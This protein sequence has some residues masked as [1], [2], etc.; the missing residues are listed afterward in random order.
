MMGL[1][2]LS[3]LRRLYSAPVRKRSCYMPHQGKRERARRIRQ[4]E[5][6]ETRHQA[7]LR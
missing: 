7:G 2:F 4:R 3:E 5:R 1:S 6:I